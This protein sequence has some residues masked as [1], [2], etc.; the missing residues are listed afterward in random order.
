MI[1]KKFIPEEFAANNYLVYNEDTK[2]AVLFD[3]AGSFDKITKFIEENKLNLEKI[4]ITHIHFD[5][6]MD[7]AAFKKKFKNVKILIPSLD[8]PLFDNLTMQCDLF[9]VRRVE[10]FVADEFIDENSKIYLDDIEIKTISTPGHSKGSSCYLINDNLI[11][12][13]TLFYEEIG[14]CD[15]PTGSFSDIARSI[16]EKLFLLD[17]NV[18]VFTGHGDNTTI[19]HEKEY[20]AY[21]GKKAHLLG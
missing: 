6:V 13:D 8:K 11:S 4:I 21:F 5:H 16:K 12:G 18:K 20:N 2:N 7:C 9:G 17:D 10:P 19:G 3:C 14:R 1:I 15:L